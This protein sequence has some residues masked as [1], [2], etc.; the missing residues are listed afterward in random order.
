MQNKLQTALKPTQGAVT[1]ATR[2]LVLSATH[3]TLLAAL[4]EVRGERQSPA[5]LRVR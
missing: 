3:P 4:G 5:P 1:P 2:V